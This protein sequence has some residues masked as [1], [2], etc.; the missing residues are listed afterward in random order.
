[1]KLTFKK[2]ET[3]VIVIVY[4]QSSATGGGLTG[5]DEN[6][7]ITG[8]YVKRDGTG[9]VLA[10]DQDVTTEGTYEAPSSAAQVRIGSSVNMIDGIYELHFHNDLFTT[11]DY[12]T[13]SLGGAA[14]MAPLLIEIQLADL[15]PNTPMRGT[16]GVQ[17]L[18]GW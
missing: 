7:S 3:G 18:H 14:N 2:S 9:V 12:V 10:V 6:S 4:I 13:I 5:L 15:D 17:N 1:M 16:D 8:G 11:A